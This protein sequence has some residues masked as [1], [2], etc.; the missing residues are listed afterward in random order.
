MLDR[1][2]MMKLVNVMLLPQ[3]TGANQINFNKLR[4]KLVTKR[5]L[6]TVVKANNE[7]I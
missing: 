2:W 1:L 3:R 4:N 6:R 5:H 7:Q